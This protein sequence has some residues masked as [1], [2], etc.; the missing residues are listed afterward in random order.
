MWCCILV[1]SRLCTCTLGSRGRGVDSCCEVRFSKSNQRTTFLHN[2][3]GTWF[4]E[5][6]EHTCI[7]NDKYIC[8]PLVECTIFSLS[9]HR[10]GFEV[11]FKSSS[12]IPLAF[13]IYVGLCTTYEFL[14][15]V[16]WAELLRNVLECQAEEKLSIYAMWVSLNPLDMA[17]VIWINMVNKKK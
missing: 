6:I 17:K 13:L 7:A 1:D 5:N 14:T 4:A 10:E 2:S 8:G 15:F 9:F 12:N 3:S 16:K 11:G